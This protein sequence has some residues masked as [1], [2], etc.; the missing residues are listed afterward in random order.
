M[1][2]PTPAPYYSLLYLAIAPLAM[3]DVTDDATQ[4]AQNTQSPPKLTTVLVTATRTEK[5]SVDLPYS[6]NAVTEDEIQHKKL[7]RTVPEALSQMPGVMVQKTG[8]AQGS[9]FI[10]GFT[11]FRTLFLID[12][13]RLNNSVFRDGPNQYWNTVDPLTIQSLEVVKGPSSVL[14]GSDAIGGTVNAV[15][16]SREQY[17]DGFSWDRRVYY[18]FADAENSHVGRAEISGS[19]NNELGFLF[20]T[21]F[22]SFGDLE[23]GEHT[24]RQAKTGYDEHNFDLKA[25]YWLT[26]DHKIVLAHQ[27]VNPN[28]AWRTHRTIFGASFEGTKVGTDKEV[29]LDQNRELTYLQYQGANLNSWIDRLR[30][31]VSYHLQSEDQLR[32]RSNLKQERSGFDVRTTGFLAQMDSD[33]PLGLWTYGV[34]Y[35]HDEVNSFQ[36][37]FSKDGILKSSEIQGP[38]ADD[39]SYDTTGVFIQDDIKLFDSLEFIIGGR[40]NHIGVDADA[41]KDVTAGKQTNLSKNWDSAVG[42]GRAIWHVDDSEHWHVFGGISQGF[43]APNLSDLTRSDIARSGELETAAQNLKPEDYVAYEFGVKSGYE[44]FSSQASYFYTD[45]ENMIVR[46]PTGRTVNGSREVTKA[47]AGNGYIHGVEIGASYRFLPEFTAFGAFTWMHGRVESFPTATS[48]KT[49]ETIDRLMPTMGNFG[50]RWDQPGNKLW[51][52]AVVTIAEEQD[53]LSSADK[54]DNQRIPPGGTPGY[55][56]L[57]LR[58]G[59]NPHPDLKLS[60][61]LE[62]VTDE[63]YRIH[64]S[65]LNEPGRNFVLAADWKF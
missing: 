61:A 35:Y 14:Y 57:T 12:G 36:N 7:S 34:D 56:A 54:A 41:V 24:G 48:P 28:D 62:N 19:L 15:T 52:E 4:Q 43:R 37:N 40:Y 3:A 65:G 26:P 30:L 32:I 47:N 45:I 1:T 25:E 22:K 23:G 10:R 53:R 51:T 33:S 64:G 50:L 21:S 9:P 44:N 38:V 49:P 16:R 17:G 29:S 6:T 31:S 39:A 60:V 2:R 13:I 5:A 59:W 63:D 55:T 46:K 18:R 58:G 8:H 27:R 11:G 20:G 42:S